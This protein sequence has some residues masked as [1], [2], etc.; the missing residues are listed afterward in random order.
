[1][2]DAAYGSRAEL[3][4]LDFVELR[5]RCEADDRPNAGVWPLGSRSV[6]SPDVSAA[7]DSA[8]SQCFPRWLSERPAGRHGPWLGALATLRRSESE[9]SRTGSHQFQ[10]GGVGLRD[11]S[12]PDDM[13]T[14]SSSI[15][16]EQQKEPMCSNESNR[17]MV[18]GGSSPLGRTWKAP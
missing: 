16:S 9:I 10:S 13:T 17:F 14:M 2:P 7:S 1:M 15:V 3:T 11:P 5:P 4:A 12:E 18:R 8:G 6:G